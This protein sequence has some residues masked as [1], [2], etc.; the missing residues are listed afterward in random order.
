MAEP[1]PT[2]A[3]E[4]PEN[5]AQLLDDLAAQFMLAEHTDLPA[6][7]QIC[8]GLAQAATAGDNAV[9]ELAGQAEAL[10]EKIILAEAD[11]PDA[12]LAEVGQAIER[13][14]QHVRRQAGGAPPPATA[15]DDATAQD[16]GGLPADVDETLLQAFVDQQYSV[17]PDVEEATLAYE[18]DRD[19]Q[20]LDSIKRILHTMKGEA[21]VCGLQEVAVACHRTEDFLEAAQAGDQPVVDMLFLVKD[22]LDKAVAAYGNKVRPTG[23]DD[24]TDRLVAGAAPSEATAEHAPE[25]EPESEPEAAAEPAGEQAHEVDLTPVTITDPDLTADFVTEAGE[26]LDLADEKL[27][28]LENDPGDAEAVNAVFRAFHTIKGVCGF[29]GL[30][31]IGNLAHAAENLLDDVRKG[32]RQF[33]D[34]VVD[35]TFSSLD[36]LKGMTAD[37]HAALQ[38]GTAFAPP[39][40]LVPIMQQLQHLLGQADDASDSPPAQVAKSDDD[41]PQPTADAAE[42]PADA[43]DDAATNTTDKRDAA[44]KAVAAATTGTGAQ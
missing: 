7:G 3:E 35:A 42:T 31:P 20:H 10:L 27:L 5:L 43:A 24:L 22:W 6:L 38:A 40:E 18:N 12:A 25:P 17:L 28:L 9:V 4:T 36:L 2:P 1:D 15:D 39:Q 34:A 41:T 29:I 26:H 16:D 30:T 13:M 37:V 32:Q 8:N 33:R 19:P 14:Q 11:D 23:L 44:E 21:G